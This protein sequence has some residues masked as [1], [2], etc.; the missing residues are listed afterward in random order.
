M[1]CRCPLQTCTR[2]GC[3]RERGVPSLPPGRPT[4]PCYGNEAPIFHPQ[5]ALKAFW[6]FEIPA[7]LQEGYGYP[8]LTTQAK[9]KILGENLLRL[10]GMDRSRAKTQSAS[11]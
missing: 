6:N 9:R 7:D 11:A 1:R 8:A 10:H 3:R 5:W 4:G 2:T